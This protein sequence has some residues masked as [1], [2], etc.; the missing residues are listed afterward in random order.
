MLLTLWR[1]CALGD[2]SSYVPRYVVSHKGA[3]G[4]LGPSVLAR[5]DRGLGVILG[6]LPS[7]ACW[8]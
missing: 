4:F 2:E 1:D 3:G 5:E 8:K 7:R 6:K